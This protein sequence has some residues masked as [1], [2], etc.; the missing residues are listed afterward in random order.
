MKVPL[1]AVLLLTLLTLLA[2]CASPPRG[3]AYGREEQL[4]RQLAESIPMKEYGYA[5]KEMRFSPDYKRALVVFTHS[6]NPQGLDNSSRRPDWEFVLAEDDF[7]RY[8]G[9]AMQPFYTP[10]TASTPPVYVTVAFPVK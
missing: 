4:R 2:G 5:I 9:M 3:A 10:G 1:A 7:G 6:D 8:Q